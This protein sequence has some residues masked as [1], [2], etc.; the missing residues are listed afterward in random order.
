MINK[1]HK[2][3]KYAGVVQDIRQKKTLSF[4]LYVTKLMQSANL[5]YNVH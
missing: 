1:K 4:D 3:P 2:K 5:V